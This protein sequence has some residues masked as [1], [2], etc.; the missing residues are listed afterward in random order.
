M[1]RRVADRSLAVGT[2]RG[3]PGLRFRPA[4]NTN[5]ASDSGADSYPR[6]ATD[7][8][9]NWVAV[10]DSD[11]SLG[12]TIG[13]DTDILVS[14]SS[15]DGATW[16]AAVALDTNA[17]TDSGVTREPQVA[18]DGAGNW[19]AVWPSDDSLG[20]TI[21]T[22][23]DILVA[24]SSDAGA[25]WTAPEA[26][27]TNAATDSG[28]DLVPEVMTDG[29]GNWV[30]VWYSDDSLGGAI[31]TDD[32]ILVARSSDAGATW[33]APAALNTNAATDSGRDW[34][35]RVATDGAGN[36]VAVWDSTDSLG[37][38][39]GID[40]DIF[41][42]RSSDAGATWTAPAAL[43]TNAAT[44]SDTDRN[45]AADDRRGRE[46]GGGL[47]LQGLA[48]RNDRHATPTS[49]SRAPATPA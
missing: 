37:G 34:A 20:S 30:A 10:W 41:V 4:L 24:R 26:L 36:W 49:S 2:A 7:G 47:G 39:I 28:N 42:S 25:T 33:T 45:T 21:G 13:T 9:G 11:D 23:Y 29:A 38:T 31:D 48:R 27:N 22:D 35:P 18:T 32:D 12:G 40:R 5:A 6:V 1:R 15:D 14:R 17:A 8:A 44:D 19:V 46:L 43:N 16:T 3:R